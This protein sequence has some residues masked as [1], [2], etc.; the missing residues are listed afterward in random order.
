MARILPWLLSGLVAPALVPT[1]RAA[2]QQRAAPPA[3]VHWDFETGDLQGWTITGGPFGKQPSDNDDDRWGGSFNKQGKYFIGTYE[4]VGD[5]PTGEIRSPVFTVQSGKLSLLIGGGSIPGKTYV[6]LC[7]ASDDT[8]LITQA[9]RNAEA[10]QRYL[11][12]LSP[13]MGEK[14]YIKTVDRE[15]GGWG[16]INLDDVRELSAEQ[17]R[18]LQRVER[19]RQEREARELKRWEASLFAPAE[20]T[21]YRGDRLA[22]IAMPMGGIGAGNIAL[23]GDGA[24]RG[25][26]IENHVNAGAVLPACFFAVWQREGDGAGT[27][28]LLQTAPIEDLP[29]VQAT[30][31]IGEYPV[32]EI[33]YE[34]PELPVKVTLRAFSPFIPLNSRDSGIPAVTYTFTAENT[35]RRPAQVA[36]LASIQNAVGWD[37]GTKIEGV[38][39][40]GYGGNVNRLEQRPDFTAIDM[41]NGALDAASPNWG[42]MTLSC[43]SR[44]ATAEPEWDDLHSLWRDFAADGALRSHEHAGPSPTGRTWNG[45]LAVSL[46]LAPRAKGSATFVI[47]WSFPNRHAEYDRNLA[48]YRIGN[49]YTNWFQDSLAAA[50]Y[51]AANF[52]RLSRET[53]LYRDTFYDSTLPYWLLDCLT[54]QTSTLCSQTCMWIEGG[55]FMAFEGA[56]CCPMNCTHVWNYEQALAK[57]FPDLERSMRETDLTVQQDPSGA[58]RHRT[59]LPLTLPRG[60]G[61]FCDGH[62]STISKAYRE[63]RQCED[64][65]WLDQYWPHIK[66]AM[67]W[68]LDAY[69]PDS[70][71]VIEGEQWNTYDCAVYG[72]NTFIGSQWLAAL[73]A[74]AEMATIEGDAAFADLCNQRFLRGWTKMDT[75]LWNAEY[76]IQTYDEAKYTRMQYGIGCHADQLLGQWWA[77]INDLGD[78]FPRNHVRQALESIFKYDWRTNFGG[79]VQTPRVFAS[80][81]DKGLLC[82]T[83]PH[84]GEPAEPTLYSHEIWTGI[85]YEV[86]GLMIYEGMLDEAYHIIKGA[87]DRY[88]GA[89]RNPWN[90]IECGDHYARAMSNWAILLAAEG[91]NYVGPSGALAFDPRITPDRFQAFFSTAAGWGSSSQVRQPRRQ[92]NVIKLAYGHLD[93]S[94]LS[95]GLPDRAEGRRVEVEVAIDGAPCDAQTETAETTLSLRL[96]ANTRINAGQE[97]TVTAKW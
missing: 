5:Q 47:S 26:Q 24:L 66:L 8:E 82:C 89:N 12:D 9:G 36:F 21:V 80:D 41:R 62:L 85:E 6:A 33:A 78:V 56:G 49:N 83:W 70:N 74:A 17:V 11:W 34:D 92:T 13:Y 95:L 7:R 55:Q 3:L 32:G 22:K 77:H 57:L 1:V 88:N 52:D 14:V 79:F 19:R 61:P 58:V 68:A 97:L 38:Q 37:A 45:A 54:S 81:D 2:E 31:F 20:R 44:N 29:T 72:P 60:T 65:S 69:D 76:W 35:G 25:W 71:G 50:E 48:Q 93:L 73:R 43:L 40:A 27:A 63:Y 87:R 94:R 42:T 91:Y 96:P 67:Q 51:V 15:S 28:K 84:G 90:E 4:G 23:C 86:A 64:R 75:D 39:F 16:H 18:D 46:N 59:V 10:M 53:L 30:E